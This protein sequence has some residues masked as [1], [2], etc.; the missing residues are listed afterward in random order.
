M[1]M[2]VI[3][4][5][6]NLLLSFLLLPFLIDAQN[7]IP[8]ASEP[9]IAVAGL[10][11]G[12]AELTDDLILERLKGLPNAC[13]PPRVTAVV[14]SY[15][16]TYVSRRTDKARIMLGRRLTYFPLF[17]QKLKAHGVPTDLKYLAV[18]ESALNP[19][20]VSRVGATGLW[21]FMP[22]TGKEYDL[23]QNTTLDERSDAVKS[24][25]AAAKYLKDLYKIYEDWALALAAYN[26]GPTRVNAAIKRAHSRNFWQIQRYLPEETRN[27]VPAF[28]A[29]SY[30]CNYFALHGLD[31][32]IPEFDEQLTTWVEVNETLTFQDI[33][34]A[35]G[36]SQEVIKNLNAGYKR[37]L[38]PASEKG[39]TLMLPQRVMPAFVN[40][41]NGRGGNRTYA[42][43][44]NIRF[45]GGDLGDGKYAHI[46]I[47]TTQSEHIDRLAERYGCNGEHLKTWNQLT[48]NYVSAGQ[49]IKIWRPIRV[50]KHEQTRIEAP[51]AAAARKPA[52]TEN[53]PA[54]PAVVPPPPPQPVFHTVQRAET[55]SDIAR[56]YNV[57]E[58]D[59]Q[60]LNKFSNLKV[61]MRIKIKA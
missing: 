13:V 39:N 17:E 29:A 45:I 56:N 55:L 58:T 43:D 28:I 8:E 61:G 9:E 46:S 18:V 60:A 23:L 26:S 48:N 12:S 41:L 3:M 14:K 27:Y 54:K 50:L 52:K 53:T 37:G 4:S 11:S 59:I 47:T 1:R 22:T 6:R 2:N 5:G 35:T 32:E 42:V 33:A 25:E 38:I 10:G 20:A 31:P 21:Q 49:K 19:L 24:T 40:W 44:E 36:L 51:A 7:M 57:K 15:I 30:I 16:Q 34:D